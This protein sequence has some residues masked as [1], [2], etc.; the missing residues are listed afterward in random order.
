MACQLLYAQQAAEKA[1]KAVLAARNQAVPK[2]HDLER[3]AALITESLPD[4][5][6]LGENCAVLTKYSVTARYD[7][8]AAWSIDQDETGQ[9]LDLSREVF[10]HCHNAVDRERDP[11]QLHQGE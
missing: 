3:L 10:G 11:N 4:F 2:T 8:G 1:L 6:A 5:P 9:A 7:P